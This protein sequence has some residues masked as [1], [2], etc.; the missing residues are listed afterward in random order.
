[1]AQN[2]PLDRARAGREMEAAQIIGS[3]ALLGAAGGIAFVLESGRRH[4]R[5]TRRA[6]ARRRREQEKAKLQARDPSFV[7][8]APEEEDDAPRD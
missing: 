1:M 8:R 5:A 4:R 3:I 7:H 2:G 6:E